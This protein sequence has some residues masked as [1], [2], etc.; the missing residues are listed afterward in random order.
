MDCIDFWNQGLNPITCYKLNWHDTNKRVRYTPQKYL[1]T[2]D[3]NPD[4]YVETKELMAM[5]N[6]N[7]HQLGFK[8][9]EFGFEKVKCKGQT[10]ISKEIIEHLKQK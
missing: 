10:W 7:S 4:D 6:L 2:A 5:F 1:K 8:I 3:F 9:K